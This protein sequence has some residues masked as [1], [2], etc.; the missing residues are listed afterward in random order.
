MC[1]IVVST[2]KPMAKET[3]D[4]CNNSSGCCPYVASFGVFETY[5][6]WQTNMGNRK[7]RSFVDMLKFEHKI[8]SLLLLMEEI[9]YQ[10]IG[11]LSHYLQ[12]FIH[13]R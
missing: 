10:L 13:L 1:R 11:S 5:N 8:Y 9:L 7:N 4:A 6:S 12:G 2:V 3:Y